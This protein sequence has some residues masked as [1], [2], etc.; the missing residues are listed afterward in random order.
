MAPIK[1]QLKPTPSSD[2][3][4]AYKNYLDKSLYNMNSETLAPGNKIPTDGVDLDIAIL[5]NKIKQYEKFGFPA[6]EEKAS[7]EALKKLRENVKGKHWPKTSTVADPKGT[8]GGSVNKAVS[9]TYIGP[10]LAHLVNNNQ[11]DC[12]HSS[13]IWHKLPSGTVLNKCSSCQMIFSA[14]ISGSTATP[15]KKPPAPKSIAMKVGRSDID[16]EFIM[17]MGM[18]SNCNVSIARLIGSSYMEETV[19]SCKVCK[20]T[21]VMS[22][23]ILVSKGTELPNSVA[24]FCTEHRHDKKVS[25]TTGRLFRDEDE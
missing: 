16:Q 7:L 5:E 14:T 19:L 24:T 13:L 1:S 17:R 9:G 2:V 18:M 12:T 3:V 8:I 20:Q 25:E 15:V 22:D 6:E 21:L 4:D 10:G 23:F 11:S